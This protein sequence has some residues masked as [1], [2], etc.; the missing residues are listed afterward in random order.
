MSKSKE[1]RNK[2]QPAL[3]NQDPLLSSKSNTKNDEEKTPKKS[4][5]KKSSKS[6]GVFLSP[7]GINIVNLPDGT[8]VASNDSS[9]KN[10][11]SQSSRPTPRKHG[12]SILKKS[13]IA[14]PNEPLAKNDVQGA[15]SE[16]STRKQKIS[17]RDKLEEVNIVENWKQYYSDDYASNSTCYCQLF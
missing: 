1:S 17:F 3:D 2:V 6:G 4:S 10:T 16:R 13:K 11:D 15:P 14:N 9:R 5:S 7:S 12:G 8:S